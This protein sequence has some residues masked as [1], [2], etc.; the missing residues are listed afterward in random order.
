[1]KVDLHLNDIPAADI[2]RDLREKAPALAPCG[3]CRTDRH[4]IFTKAHENVLW[5]QS[6]AAKQNAIIAKSSK[7][8]IV[9][10]D[11][12]TVYKAWRTN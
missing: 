8:C 10:D 6:A 2:L 5:P 1:M 12:E 3:F 4:E 9:G 7:K 11:A